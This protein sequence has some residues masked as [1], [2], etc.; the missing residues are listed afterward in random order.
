MA[1]N[2]AAKKQ[3]LREKYGNGKIKD[4]DQ[5][6]DLLKSDENPCGFVGSVNLVVSLKNRA[7]KAGSLGCQGMISL[8]H[9]KK[10]PKKVVVFCEDSHASKAEELGFIVGNPEKIKKTNKVDGDIIFTTKAYF[11]N[12]R[13]IIPV[14]GKKRLLPNEK[15]GTLVAGGADEMLQKAKKY[16]D[17][18]LVAYKKAADD[19]VAMK[20][21][22]LALSKDQ[23]RENLNAALSQL[24]KNHSKFLISKKI[25]SGTMF[26]VSFEYKV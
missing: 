10:S 23:L 6:I 4:L 21:G 20:I 13:S 9:G 3:A 11:K 17:G 1:Q 16:Q 19:S 7:K 22:S 8:L 5:F 26:P 24:E 18:L 25:L 15:N 12:L 2:S 14:L